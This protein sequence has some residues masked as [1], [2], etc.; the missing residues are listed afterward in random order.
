MAEAV[1]VAASISIITVG[2][3]EGIKYAKTCYRATEELEALQVNGTLKAILRS[4]FY[5]DN[6]IMRGSHSSHFRNKS[7]SLPMW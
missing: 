4:S 3:I 6:Q 2:V 1:G 5:E 7:S